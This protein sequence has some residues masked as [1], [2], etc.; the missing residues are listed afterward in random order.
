MQNETDKGATLVSK[1]LPVANS[2]SVNRSF[3]A[4]KKKHYVLMNERKFP[5]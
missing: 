3:S 1:S 5:Y 2:T 4:T